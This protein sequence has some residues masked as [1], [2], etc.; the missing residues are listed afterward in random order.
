[1]IIIL[2][3]HLQGAW[4]VIH[5]ICLL[6]YFII[7]AFYDLAWLYVAWQPCVAMH[8]WQNCDYQHPGLHFVILVVCCV[9]WEWQLWAVSS[10]RRVWVHK[11]NMS[12]DESGDNT[13]SAAIWEAKSVQYNSFSVWK[14]C[15]YRRVWRILLGAVDQY[16]E[17]WPVL[18]LPLSLNNHHTRPCGNSQQNLECYTWP[19]LTTR[20]TWWWSHFGQCL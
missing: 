18:W 19:C 11:D 13:I 7:F 2:S 20:W 16:P 1:M 17:Q 12:D 14:V 5:I 6:I 8:M 10:S 4:E 9:K 15:L 3:T